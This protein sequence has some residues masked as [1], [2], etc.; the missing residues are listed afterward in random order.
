MPSVTINER[1]TRIQIE[2]GSLFA[3]IW[4]PEGAAGDQLAPVLLFHD[5]LGCVD[6]WR[7]FP[8]ALAAETGRRVIAYDRS[9]PYLGRLSPGFIRRE[10]EYVVP[11]LCEY[12]HMQARYPSNARVRCESRDASSEQ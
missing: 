2:E 4:T 5:S 6:L 9:D 1:E 7:S 11:R 12:L 8:K 3:K 10:A